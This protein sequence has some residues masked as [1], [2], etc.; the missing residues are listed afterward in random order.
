[1]RRAT[2]PAAT[3]C[4]N[5]APVH[6]GR[7]LAAQLEARGITGHALAL[8]LKVPANRVSDII[9]GRRSVSAETP[10]KLGRYL[11][12]TPAFWMN[13]QTAY[14]VALAEHALGPA[15]EREVSAP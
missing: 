2:Q 7:I 9:R 8:E 1:M 15:V 5:S 6:P 13:A 14:D 3:D 11:R 12:T 4:P 10:V